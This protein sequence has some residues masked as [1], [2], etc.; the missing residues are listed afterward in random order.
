LRQTF[1][2]VAPANSDQTTSTLGNIKHVKHEIGRRQKTKTTAIMSNGSII[3]K[4]YVGNDSLLAEGLM[5]RGKK[6]QSTLQERQREARGR[7]KDNG[8]G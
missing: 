4:K 2:E 5:A 8:H 1:I 3:H 7:G 6:G